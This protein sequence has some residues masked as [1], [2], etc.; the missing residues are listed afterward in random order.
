MYGNVRVPGPF[1]SILIIF[2]DSSSEVNRTTSN[3]ESVFLHC[4]VTVVHIL[5]YL[6]DIYCET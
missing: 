4:L 1:I 2:C 3:G 6:I 5:K